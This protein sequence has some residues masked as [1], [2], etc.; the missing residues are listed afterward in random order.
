M[1]LFSISLIFCLALCFGATTM[2]AQNVTIPGANFK[3]YL[4]GN[5]TINTNGDGEIQISEALAFSGSINCSSLGITTLTGIEAFVNL[6]ELDC[7]SNPLSSLDVTQNTSLTVLY[8]NGNQLSSLDVTQNANLEI[9]LC[10]N[11]QLSNLDMTQNTSLT[12]LYCNGNQ[13]S[14]LDVTQNTNL[15][16]L[17]CD[18]NQLSNLEVAQNTSL[19]ILYC[20][21]EPV[22]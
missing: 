12:I 14:S 7:H 13:L 17:L 16:I 4:V 3:A 9:L 5:A 21:G 8:C 10:D 2:N 1:N 19:T 15:K 6:T 22:K 18:N 11:N 20:N